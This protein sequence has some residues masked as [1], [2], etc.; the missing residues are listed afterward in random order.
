[1]SHQIFGR[2]SLAE[3]T[4]LETPRLYAIRIYNDDYTPMDFVVDLLMRIFRK[5]SEEARRIMM[6]VHVA[7][8]QVVGIYSYDVAATKHNQARLMAE[9]AGHPLKISIEE[10]K[11]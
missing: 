7:G 10:V 3:D 4:R 6:D 8:E 9:G 11:Q 1:M 2:T 5:S